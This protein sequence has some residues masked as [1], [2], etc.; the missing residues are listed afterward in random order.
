MRS[1]RILGVVFLAT[2]CVSAG[3]AADNPERFLRAQAELAAATGGRARS[4]VNPATSRARLV[5]VPRG[6]LILDGPTAKAKAEDFFLRYGA[7]LGVRAGAGDL[8]FVRSSTDGIGMTHLRFDQSYRGLPV[9]GAQ[10]RVHLDAAGE[11][12][13]VNGAL[14]P[15]LSLDTSPR[16]DRS[17][18]ETIACSSVAKE[19]GVRPSHFDVAESRLLIYR[20][21]LI[22]GVPGK[23]HLAWQVE[24]SSGDNLRELV[25]LDAHDGLVIDR[26]DLIH[27]ITRRIYHHDT[28]TT[29]WQEGDAL[30]FSGLDSARDSEVNDV[31]ETTLDTYEFFANLTGGSYLS[32]NGNDIAMRTIYEADALVDEGRCENATW[33]GFTTNFC[34]GW[35]VDD[36]A[37]HE[38]THAYTES[39]HN[40]IYAWQ[41]GALN[42]SFSDI[43]GEIVDQL[44]GRGIDDPSPP[45]PTGTCTDS[46]GINTP[47]LEVTAPA[48]VARTYS[49]Q[50]AT[51]NPDQWSLSGMVELVDDGSGTTSDACEALVGFTAGNIALIDRGECPFRDKVFNAEEAGAT[52]IIVANHEGED[53]FRMTALDTTPGIPGI[54]I[55]LADGQILKSA[56]AQGLRVSMSDRSASEDTVRWLMGEDINGGPIRDMWHPNCFEDPARVWDGFYECTSLD[57]GGVHINSGIPNRAFALLV[58][59]GTANR[60]EI[61]PIGM[62]KAAHIYWRAMSVYQGPTTNFAEHADILELSC[63]DLVGQ[64]ITSLATGNT[65]GDTISGNDCE[66]VA[67]AMTAVDMRAAPRCDFQT[68]LNPD[69]PALPSGKVIFSETF[70][71]DPGPAW[72]VTSEG[73]Y[74][75]YDEARSAWRWTNDVPDEGSGGALWAINSVLIG[76]CEPNDDDQSGVTRLESPEIRIPAT[77]TGAVLAFDHWVYTEDGWDG[78]NLKISVNGSE[79]QIVPSA[80]FIHNPYN[81]SVIVTMTIEDEEYTN[82]NPLSGEAAYTGE[83]EGHVFGGSWGQSQIDLGFFADPGD[84]VRLRWD[85]G[86][87]GCNGRDGWYIDNVTVIAEGVSPSATRRPSGR[88]APARGSSR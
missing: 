47:L 9:F 73:V 72:P 48:T 40:L 84:S 13:V 8:E 35:A 83:D 55:G 62:T 24:I 53:P 77:A 74:P 37:A 41:P 64:P 70:N 18:A 87:D 79:Y 49:S 54:S 34:R 12:R 56:L 29:I 10:L 38:W 39:S 57:N 11:V 32:Y 42:E 65:I 33:N 68:I 7:L 44:N 61:A 71:S 5:V 60:L 15:D 51:W 50:T 6:S 30:P 78:G 1:H 22:Q 36:V 69:P 43:F 82:T 23:N 85:F 2:V 66:Q 67:K 52:A 26:I 86:I 17:L 31:I 20:S 16:V 28:N 88:R 58:D 76:N 21:G 19:N 45:R 81:S 46:G 80:A 25:F 75:E 59:G 63:A 4:V 27:P 14:I 3:Y